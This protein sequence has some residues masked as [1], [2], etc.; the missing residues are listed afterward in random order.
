M[1][2]SIPK[3]VRE[4]WGEEATEE[5]LRWFDQA[6]QE[7]AVSKDEFRQILSRLDIL[8]RDVEGVKQEVAEVKQELKDLRREM[9][10]RFD[11]MNE[12]FD[13]MYDRIL[14]MIRWT[15]GVIALFGTAVTILLA[16]AQFTP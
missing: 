9:N 1:P 14:L 11:R 16:V 3:S 15:I 2:V 10:E 6:V 12:R 5:F 7:V 4:A 13:E 8:E